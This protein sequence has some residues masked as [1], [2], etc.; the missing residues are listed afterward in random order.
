MIARAGRCTLRQLAAA[1][2]AGPV[3]G[4]ALDHALNLDGG[5]SADLWIGESVR[6]GPH[7]VRPF[8]NKPVRNFL[9]LRARR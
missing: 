3:D 4:L 6:G 5:R 2:A 1:L 9:V 8:W 7:R